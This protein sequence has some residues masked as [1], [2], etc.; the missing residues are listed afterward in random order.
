MITLRPGSLHSR[1]IIVV[2]VFAFV[3][4]LEVSAPFS[5]RGSYVRAAVSVSAPM[6]LHVVGRQLLDGSNQPLILRGVNR[7]GS[8]YAC[9]QGW[10]FFD[11]PSDPASVQAIASWSAAVNAVRIPLNEDCWLN[12][13]GAPPAYSGAAYQNAISSYVGTVQGAGLVPILELHWSGAGN[14]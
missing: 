8:E 14:T 1:A 11:G 7:S 12:I 5:G 9:I 4:G 13:N 2:F 6:G 10:G 3:A